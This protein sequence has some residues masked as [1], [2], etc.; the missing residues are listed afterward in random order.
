[1]NLELAPSTVSNQ[2]KATKGPSDGLS[3]FQILS[4]DGGGIKGL[5]TAAILAH[6]EED[7]KCCIADSFDLIVGTS[8]GG[9]IALGL[10][11]GMR[12]REIVEFYLSKGDSI[13]PNDVL[14]YRRLRQYLRHKF[15]QAP[16]R[17]A[18]QG[19]FGDKLLGHST[20]RLVIPSYDLG[21]QEV[22]LFKTAHAERLAR[23]YKLPAWKVALATSAAPT[24]F[25][26][27]REIEGRRLIDGG[28]W[29]NNPTVVGITEAV[30]VL[31]APLEEVSVL[32]M[33][34]TE[35][36][37]HRADRLDK[38]G[39]WQWKNDAAEVI[40]EGQSVAAST[41]ALLLLGKERFMRVTA[42]VPHRLF[43]LDKLEPEKLRAA[44]GHV[45]LH[46]G[47]EIKS[48]FL[49]HRAPTFTP[50]HQL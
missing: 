7:L 24:F 21:Q 34:T 19:C 42:K 33:G 6:W 22:R 4:L 26:A 3:Q 35:E 10:G 29:A 36:V 15:S 9:I 43:G 1:M 12:P 41:Q 16:L 23:D 38:G 44:A 49:G 47:P 46:A 37:R 5:F 17:N 31:G 18:L 39:F 28:V 50:C 45:S 2:T 30:A 14:G 11:L 25:P 20:K 13:F 32:S 27:C 8:T 40:M 48:R